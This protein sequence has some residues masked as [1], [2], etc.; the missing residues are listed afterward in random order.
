MYLFGCVRAA[1][2]RTAGRNRQTRGSRLMARQGVLRARRDRSSGGTGDN[3][4]QY[5]NAEREFHDWLPLTE[6]SEEIY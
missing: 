3:D 4:G 2:A 6:K 5:K 1:H